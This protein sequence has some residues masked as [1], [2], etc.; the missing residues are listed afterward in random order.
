MH[1]YISEENI[2]SF[3]MFFTH[4]QSLSPGFLPPKE[5]GRLT[6]QG[7]KHPQ[8][9]LMKAEG[10]WYCDVWGGITQTSKE[11]CNLGVPWCYAADCHRY[12][13]ESD[14]HQITPFSLTTTHMPSGSPTIQ[15][16]CS[17]QTK[18]KPTVNKNVNNF[19]KRVAKWIFIVYYF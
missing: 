18:K 8:L 13:T 19:P 16:I 9:L 14:H 10:I 11:F 4:S 3:I 2:H 1:I 12:L 17:A 5:T 7:T 6:P 15:A